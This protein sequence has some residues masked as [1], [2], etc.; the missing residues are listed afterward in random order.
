MVPELQPLSADHGP[1]V[2]ALE[3]ENRDYFAGSIS[4]RGD[5]FFER[6][7]EVL[8][9]RLA[10]QEDGSGAY[11]VLVAGDGAILGRF[12]LIFVDGG[13]AELGYR[14]ARQ[15]AG[16]GVAT[17][18]VRELCG[19]AASQHGI[20]TIRAATSHSNVASQRIL[21]NNGFRPAGDAAPTDIGGKSGTWYQLD[22][23]D[24]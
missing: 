7:A 21:L 5:E 10:E 13:V 1:A 19:L 9:A 23:A 6:F 4:D 16:R 11:Y 3:I 8:A 22:L 18:Y 2:L 15:T 12:N 17:A 20:R 24:G 14:V